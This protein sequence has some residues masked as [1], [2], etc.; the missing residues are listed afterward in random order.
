MSNGKNA[1][2]GQEINTIAFLTFNLIL[3]KY[4][5]YQRPMKKLL[6]S[7]LFIPLLIACGSDNDEP[8]YIDNGIILGQ[9]SYI[10]NAESMVFD[11]QKDFCYLV[12]YDRCTKLELQRTGLGNYKLTDSKV[13]F[14]NSKNGHPYYILKDTLFLSNNTEPVYAKYIRIKS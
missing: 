10:L 14:F 8:N 3:K 9:W 6:L 11:F 5:K 2:Q 4:F 7:L 1:I 13:F 12:T